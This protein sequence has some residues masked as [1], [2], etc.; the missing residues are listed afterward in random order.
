MTTVQHKAHIKKNLYGN[1]GHADLENRA[2]VILAPNALYAKRGSI[3]PMLFHLHLGY[4]FSFW[5]IRIPASFFQSRLDY[6]GLPLP[7]KFPISVHKK[8]PLRS[9]PIRTAKVM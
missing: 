6:V 8:G 3:Q 2:L 4:Y 9:D 7:A 1:E 5:V